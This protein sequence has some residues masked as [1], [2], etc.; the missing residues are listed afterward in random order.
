MENKMKFKDYLL[1]IKTF[2]QRNYRGGRVRMVRLG[3][4]TVLTSLAPL[5]QAF[6][7]Y[8]GKPKWKEGTI[9]Y[10]VE[11]K[12]RSSAQKAFKTWSE[13]VDNKII[14]EEVYDNP[15]LEIK[16]GK[17]N[18]NQFVAYASTFQDINNI[19][20]KGKIT[21]NEKMDLN[22]LGIDL[23]NLIT[24]ETGH[25]LGLADIY[26]KNRI[27]APYDETV[28][29]PTM[30]NRQTTMKGQYSTLHQEDVNGIRELYGLD[31]KNNTLELKRKGYKIYANIPKGDN[32]IVWTL[33]RKNKEYK[34]YTSNFIRRK[35]GWKISAEYNGINISL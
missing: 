12:Y 5:V 28:D 24:H 16:T 35:K 26:D 10:Q 18:D 8:E 17:L 7:F 14:F 33:R 19:T 30:W 1:W 27:T 29:M 4:I 15:Q 2:R 34:L 13:S 32:N 6:E 11:D 20:I 3:L 23:D 31:K 21:V 9:T 25:I 22:K